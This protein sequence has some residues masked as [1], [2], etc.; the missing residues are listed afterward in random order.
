MAAMSLVPADA[1]LDGEITNWATRYK[2]RQYGAKWLMTLHV[3]SIYVSKV[4][5]SKSFQEPATHHHRQPLPACIWQVQHLMALGWALWS[6]VGSDLNRF[7]P[8]GVA[9]YNFCNL[10]ILWN[11]ST[12]ESD[13]AGPAPTEGNE[14]CTLP[15][16]A[17]YTV[18]V[19]LKFAPTHVKLLC[20]N[21]CPAPPSHLSH[22][23]LLLHHALIHASVPWNSHLSPQSTPWYMS[24][25]NFSLLH[26]SMK[27]S[28][29][30]AAV[31][32]NCPAQYVAFKCVQESVLS[33]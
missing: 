22:V 29:V 8:W 15:H 19:L 13:P 6:D 16:I 25:R 4:S 24:M 11:D 33:T 12:M 32:A 10:E 17:S 7:R 2:T 9:I 20:S 18:Y 14:I 1:T 31:R 3:W 28:I 23:L 30:Y 26:L 27:S 5:C 21:P